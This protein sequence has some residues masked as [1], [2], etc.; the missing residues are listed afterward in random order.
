MIRDYNLEWLEKRIFI[1]WQSMTGIMQIVAAGTAFRSQQSATSLA[2]AVA[3]SLVTKLATSAQNDGV[4][5]LF[6]A[7]YDLDIKKAIRFRV[8]YTQT[9]ASGTVSWKV[10][11]AALLDDAGLGTGGTVIAA[12]AV[13]LDTVIP[14]IV[15]AGVTSSAYMVTGF[16]QINRGTLVD[17]T[18]SLALAVTTTD[19]A[20]VAGL[21]ILGLEV[22]YSS[23]RTSGPR[24]NVIGGR[25]LVT[26]RPLGVQLATGQEGL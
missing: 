7:P 14:A 13:A 8:H 5:H 22:R 11:Y 16:G 17:T 26:T 24:R 25:R 18:T 15:T 19:A 3:A 10:L 6:M 1:P 9:A 23:R 20:P 4:S 12:P 2:T 21:G